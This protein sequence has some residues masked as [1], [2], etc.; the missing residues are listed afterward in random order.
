MY[1]AR[2]DVRTVA[3]QTNFYQNVRTVTNVVEVAV[4][5]TN[6]VAGVETAD[7]AEEIETE[8]EAEDEP[9]NT[10][11]MGEILPHRP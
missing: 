10:M 4:V 2:T 5:L 6:F 7:V 11:R 9:M 8:A 1:V 3:V